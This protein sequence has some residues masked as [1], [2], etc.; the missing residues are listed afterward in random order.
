M[1]E[2]PPPKKP[3]NWACIPAAMFPLR[4]YIKSTH[5]IFMLCRSN[6][7]IA[8]ALL[9]EDYRDGDFFAY[10]ND[11]RRYFWMSLSPI[12]DF[13][14]TTRFKSDVPKWV[15]K[16]TRMHVNAIL[17]RDEKTPIPELGIYALACRKEILLDVQVLGVQVFSCPATRGVQTESKVVG[18][19][20]FWAWFNDGR[21]KWDKQGGEPCVEVHTEPLEADSQ[22]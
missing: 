21:K 2:E 19:V 6:K 5:V 8:R 7:V 10:L 13:Y 12:V 1:E 11:L 22:S 14:L 4:H 16:A 3:L 15:V 9:C 18:H 20:K 17:D